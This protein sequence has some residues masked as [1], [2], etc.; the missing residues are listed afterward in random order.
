MLTVSQKLEICKLVAAARYSYI[1]IASIY[2]I[3]WQTVCDIK[4][5]EKELQ[6]FHLKAVEMNMPDMKVM[7]TGQLDKLDEAL[8]LWFKQKQENHVDVSGVLLVE[9]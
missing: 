5:K 1:D 9:L 8:Y 4:K 2:G 6:Q 7:R 3:G